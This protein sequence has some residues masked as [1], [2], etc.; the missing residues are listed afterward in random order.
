MISISR[1]RELAEEE[2]ELSNQ[3]IKK[4]IISNDTDLPITVNANKKG[5][6]YKKNGHLY[7]KY[8]SCSQCKNASWYDD[9]YCN[10]Q[11]IHFID[12]D[13]IKTTSVYCENY[14][15]INK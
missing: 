12:K 2:L 11:H 5:N 9:D 15:R 1:M 3:I 8:M 14:E 6:R 13:G 7:C 4:R 10:N